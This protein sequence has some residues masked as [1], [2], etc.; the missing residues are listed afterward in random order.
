MS[1][2]WDGLIEVLGPKRINSLSKDNKEIDPKK[3]IILLKKHAIKTNDVLWRGKELS[4]KELEE[5]YEMIQKIEQNKVNFGYLCSSCDPYL[6]LIC[7]LFQ[8]NITHNF[9]GAKIKYQYKSSNN[10]V[11]TL[12]VESNDN[13]FWIS[14]TKNSL[15][16]KKN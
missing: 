2:F 7:Q 3:F 13:H 1:C 8:V 5:N 6:L 4:E 12:F 11:P 10:Y 16:G 14:K 15:N 9:C